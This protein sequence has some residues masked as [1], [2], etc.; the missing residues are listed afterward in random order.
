METAVL[1]AC[2][3]FRNGVRDFLLWLAEAG[4]FSPAW[5][6]NIHDEWMRN[7]H[8]KFGDPSETLVHA[9]TEMEKAFPGANFDPDPTTLKSLLLPDEG[10]IHVVA[11]AVAAEA[12]TIIT[13][14]GPH[15]PSHILAPLGLRT[16]R[17]D[18]FCARLFGKAQIE[19]T[20]GVRLHRASMKRPAYDRDE[21]L[22]HLE[23]NLVLERTA[24][25]LRTVQGVI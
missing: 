8:N 5:S 12:D 16:E 7:R 25:L 17:P 10:D 20:E 4:A 21:Y 22:D 13:Y 9:R 11:T 3:L 6:N 15:F 19:I 23:I 1:D 2:V 18:A 24:Q 14:N